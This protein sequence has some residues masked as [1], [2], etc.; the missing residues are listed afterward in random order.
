MSFHLSC[1]EASSQVECITT[2]WVNMS[3]Y[4]RHGVMEM[5]TECT[6]DKV[7]TRKPMWTGSPQVLNFVKQ[8]NPYG[9]NIIHTG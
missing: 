6:N 2:Q 3:G 1:G 9:N 5:E 7:L 4:F 8:Y